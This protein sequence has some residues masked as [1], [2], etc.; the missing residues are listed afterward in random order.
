MYL[1]IAML[2]YFVVLF[3]TLR[4]IRI[5]R[6]TGYRSYRK[7][8][9]RGLA[10]SS[11][12]LIGAIT[13]EAQPNIGLLIVLIGLFINRKGMRERVFTGAGTLDRFLGKTD[14]VKTK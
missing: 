10:A 13:V 8:A 4:D 2:A 3:L 12:I 9:L 1:E 14:Y 6:R 11:L 5:F 7:G